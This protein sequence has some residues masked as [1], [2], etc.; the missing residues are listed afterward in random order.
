MCLVVCRS[1][2]DLKLRNWALEGNSPIKTTFTNELNAE[3]GKEP[4]KS[5]G[6]E[7][8]YP[9]KKCLCISA[10]SADER[11]RKD[12]TGKP[13]NEGKYRDVRSKEESAYQA[14]G[15]D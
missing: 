2:P 12:G 11:C 15:R 14:R 7:T 9:A 1:E 5:K 13:G 8:L 3:R 6:Q 10:H 4:A